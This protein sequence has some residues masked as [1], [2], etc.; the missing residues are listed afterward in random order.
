MAVHLAS[1]WSS[2]WVEVDHDDEHGRTIYSDGEN[3]RVVADTSRKMTPRAKLF[4]DFHNKFCPEI[5]A[6]LGGSGSFSDPPAGYERAWRI[7]MGVNIDGAMH[8]ICHIAEGYSTGKAYNSGDCSIAECPVLL[9][10][11]PFHIETSVMN[12]IREEF[13]EDHK[14]KVPV[15]MCLAIT[16]KPETAEGR[17][18]A[19]FL[20][21]LLNGAEID[22]GR[23]T[24]GKMIPTG[25]KSLSFKRDGFPIEFW[26]HASRAQ[27]IDNALRLEQD[28]RLVALYTEAK[29]LET[30]LTQAEGPLKDNLKLGNLEGE[31]RA[32][33]RARNNERIPAEKK[34]DVIAKIEAK[35]STLKDE[36]DALEGKV[37]AA[38]EA[39]EAFKLDNRTDLPNSY[40]EATF[41]VAF[42]FTVH[43]Q[44]NGETGMFETSRFSNG[45]GSPP[46]SDSE[47]SGVSRRSSGGSRFAATEDTSPR[48]MLDYDFNNKFCLEIQAM[49]GGSG[50]F[51]EPPAGYERAWRIFMGVNIVGAMH[52]IYHIAEGYST[53]KAYNCG[54]CSIADCPVQLRGEPFHIE[55]SVMDR[56]RAEF[57]EDHK[58]K[59]PVQ[60]C[61]AITPRPETAQ[62]FLISLLKGAE[63]DT[64]SYTVRKMKPTGT[65][66]LSFKRDPIEF[67]TH[68]SRAQVI[69]NALR[70]EQDPTLVALYTKAKLLETTLTQAEMPLKYNHKLGN[71]EGENRALQRARNNERIPAEKK[72]DV[73]AKIEAKISTLKDERDALEGKVTAAKEAIE[74][75]KRENGTALPNSYLEATFQVAFNFTVHK[76]YN[77]ETGMFETSRFS[78]DVHIRYLQT[79][80][81]GDSEVDGPE[82]VEEAEERRKL[83]ELNERH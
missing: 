19:G 1:I 35:I 21:S 29:H 3:Y 33:Q 64:G 76:Q 81:L 7:F 11:E 56:I 45:D 74:A 32:L 63:I 37:T 83:E 25:T 54:D 55:T 44:Y 42:D 6:M 75:F 10:G 28:P 52:F 2:K 79:M 48:G 73:I 58:G 38:K 65:K 5:Q 27:V 53:A 49:L 78:N 22:T 24:V 70:L 13:P 41:Q 61:L 34:P 16:P 50:S 82:G 30:T 77:G 60:M 68:A 8:F 39:I 72:P 26:T 46:G 18:N 51:S 15:Q 14:G 23:Y 43:K 12:R 62:G 47:P 71:L 67:W 59:V 69:D 57:P 17:M 80:K 31:N 66:P 40:L 4:Q 9:R 36:R 20:I